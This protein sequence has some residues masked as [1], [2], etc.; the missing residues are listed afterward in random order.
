MTHPSSVTVDAFD[1]A[2][3]NRVGLT[4][5]RLA[6]ERALAVG[7]E[8]F[9]GTSQVFLALL[10]GAKPDNLEWLRKKRNVVLRFHRSSQSMRLDCAERGVDFEQRF[11]LPRSDYVASG[12]AVLR[13]AGLVGCVTV[14]GLPDTEDDRL[15]R[16]ALAIEAGRV[17]I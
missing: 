11:G 3:A 13:A 4:L 1:Y 16:E 7:I 10:P 2:A 15:V 9:H 14:S 6:T 8:A 17:S 12:G 5:H